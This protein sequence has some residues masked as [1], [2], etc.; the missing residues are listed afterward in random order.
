MGFTAS[1]RRRLGARLKRRLVPALVALVAFP[2]A[3]QAAPGTATPQWAVSPLS[4]ADDGF[5][6]RLPALGTDVAAPDQRASGYAP[7]TAPA[8]DPEPA[9]SSFDWVDTAVGAVACLA[10]FAI[11]AAL[12]HRRRRA[13]PLPG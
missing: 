10:A 5:A 2:A 7:L 9:A 8:Q 13:L 4:R 12:G 1:W 3:A 11:A 6:T